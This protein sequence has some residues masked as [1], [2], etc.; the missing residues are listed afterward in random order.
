MLID[1]TWTKDEFSC[2]FY[3]VQCNNI[4]SM[5][6]SKFGPAGPTAAPTQAP[7]ATQAPPPQPQP[8]NGGGQGGGGQ[9]GSQGGGQGGGG[10]GGGGQNGRPRDLQEML[11]EL[12]HE[13]E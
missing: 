1:T 5:D 12:L 2:V 7:P 8:P 4:E 6:L 13:L 10:Q 3:R 11:E 9:G